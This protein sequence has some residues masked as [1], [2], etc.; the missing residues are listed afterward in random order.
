MAIK[1]L[2]RL[3]FNGFRA[4]MTTS[5]EMLFLQQFVET[6]RAV[7][8]NTKTE[9]KMIR[10]K[11][12]KCNIQVYSR[13]H[14]APKP[15]TDLRTSTASDCGQVARQRTTRQERILILTHGN[16]FFY[17]M[18]IAPIPSAARLSGF[19]HTPYKQMFIQK[20]H[21]KT[22]KNLWQKHKNPWPK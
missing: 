20:I 7:L 21:R 2:K 22:T 11:C 1:A 5:K 3:G 12:Y 6:A 8:A 14:Y 4:F 18:C 9:K 10:H 13:S 15:R 19:L 16:N 17:K